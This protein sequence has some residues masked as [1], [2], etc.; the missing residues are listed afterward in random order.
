MF[1]LLISG[2]DYEDHLGESVFTR[3]GKATSQKH[4]ERYCSLF[5]EEEY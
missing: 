3:I 2:N 5:Q 1:S 4:F